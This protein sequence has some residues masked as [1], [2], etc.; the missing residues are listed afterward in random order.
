M[1]FTKRACDHLI[2]EV[3]TGVGAHLYLDVQG[4]C[5]RPKKRSRP[6]LWKFVFFFNCSNWVEKLA[7]QIGEGHLTNSLYKQRQT[8]EWANVNPSN[9]LTRSN[10]VNILVTDASGIRIGDWLNWTVQIHLRWCKYL[11]K[12]KSKLD[13]HLFINTNQ[14]CTRYHICYLVLL[15]FDE[16]F[17]RRKTQ[18]TASWKQSGWWKFATL[19]QLLFI[20][21]LVF[22]RQHAEFFLSK[23]IVKLN[24]LYGF[25]SRYI[26]IPWQSQIGSR[27]RSLKYN[28]TKIVDYSSG[29]FLTIFVI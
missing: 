15:S 4:A 29:E 21:Y 14:T 24:A 7:N 12:I 18:R 6:T 22:R 11:K 9:C 26:K 5:V 1:L 25:D 20:S 2:L 16:S 8:F 13:S 27:W 3:R 10:V 17:W 19:E 28:S 23:K